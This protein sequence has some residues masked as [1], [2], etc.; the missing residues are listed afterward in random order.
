MSVTA[1]CN[2]ARYSARQKIPPLLPSVCYVRK[3]N[4]NINK[5]IKLKLF[6]QN[7]FWMN[8][9]FVEAPNCQILNYQKQKNEICFYFGTRVC[10]LLWLRRL[11]PLHKKTFFEDRTE[12]KDKLKNS[13]SYI[14]FFHT[15]ISKMGYIHIDTYIIGTIPYIEFFLILPVLGEQERE[16]FTPGLLIRPRLGGEVSYCCSKHNL[17]LICRSR[18]TR[19]QKYRF[20]TFFL[21]F[22]QMN[23]D[24]KLARRR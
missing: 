17:S 5:I 11:Y 20:A 22:F 19:A 13:Q 4:F 8:V 16:R 6:V 21:P 14:L 7:S 9:L 24:F 18:T 1:T 23:L 2:V 12:W 10:P 3:L 15:G